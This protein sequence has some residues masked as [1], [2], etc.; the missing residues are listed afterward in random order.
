MKVY[1]SLGSNLGDRVQ[2]LRRA[3]TLIDLE[4][5][6]ILRTSSFYETAP[7]KVPKQPW[8][9]NCVAEGR[10]RLSPPSLL[11]LAQ[12]IERNM[13]RDRRRS[14]GPRM[15]DID[16]LLFGDTV[17]QTPKL[18]IPHQRIGG[19]RF[20]LIPLCELS[21]RLRHP[22]T[23]RT[24]RDMLACTHDRSPVIWCCRG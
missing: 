6:R 7:V 5:I 24:V 10:A 22:V 12:G 21:E 9:M 8:F 19:R 15:I 13:G 23:Q 16:I 1:F 11:K 4:G 18:T 3:L 2:N 14:K 17:L 20:V